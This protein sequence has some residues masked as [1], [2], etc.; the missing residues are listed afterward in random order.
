MLHNADY[1]QT[2]TSDLVTIALWVYVP[3]S[4]VEYVWR[5]RNL[6]FDTDR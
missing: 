6:G 3:C 1:D 2:L 4:F 5:L